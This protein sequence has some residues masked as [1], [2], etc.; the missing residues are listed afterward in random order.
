MY[1]NFSETESRRFS[2]RIFRGGSIAPE[3]AVDLLR[4]CIERE[5]DVVILR[6]EQ[7][8]AADLLDQLAGKCHAIAADALIEFRKPLNQKTIADRLCSGAEIV[9]IDTTNVH[10]LD[11]LVERCYAEYRNHYHANP[12]L[13]RQGV[14]SGLVEFSKSFARVK[15]R[16]VLV[17][18]HKGSPC[19][20]LC[21]EI[22]D[23]DAP[24]G[25]PTGSHRLPTG[26][27]VIGGSAL[28]IPQG[29]RHKV[30]CD[31]TH[32]G[33]LWLLER[34]VAQFKA[35]TRTDKTYI[36]KLLIRNMHCMPSRSLATIHINLFL[37]EI[38]RQ[39]SDAAVVIPQLDLDSAAHRTT[40]LEIRKPHATTQRRI[41]ALSTGAGKFYFCADSDTSGI[42][43]IRSVAFLNDTSLR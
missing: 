28:D 42:T 4:E 12:C 13:D 31:L 29:L 17:A 23:G 6:M 1:V 30:L 18:L 8:T 2:F 43:G 37:S 16:T 7:E 15:N 35:L 32:Y 38:K 9:E 34:G 14:L 25:Q 22:R 40:C 27:S 36:Q 20:Y 41:L 39:P 33:D 24:H 10:L 5:A 11:G 21:M 3:H 26:S 19:G